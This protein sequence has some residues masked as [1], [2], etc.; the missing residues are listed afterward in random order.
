M[1]QINN[2][3]LGKKREQFSMLWVFHVFIAMSFVV[4]DASFQRKMVNNDK[5]FVNNVI[6]KKKKQKSYENFHSL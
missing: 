5:L 6:K 1:K 2:I 4:A 3:F